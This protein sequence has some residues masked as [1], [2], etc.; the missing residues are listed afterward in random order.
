MGRT[1]FTLEAEDATVEGL[2]PRKVG[3]GKA[4]VVQGFD[5]RTQDIAPGMFRYIFGA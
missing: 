1:L 3:H 4:D 5:H 2:G